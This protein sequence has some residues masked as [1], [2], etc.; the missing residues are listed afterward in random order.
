MVLNPHLTPHFSEFLESRK[1]S[2]R[3]N[4]ANLFTVEQ[5]S[6][7]IIEVIFYQMYLSMVAC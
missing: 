3:S 7:V 1:N 6:L 5:D 4:A 2:P